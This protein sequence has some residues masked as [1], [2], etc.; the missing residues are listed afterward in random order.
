MNIDAED[1]RRHYA[2]LNDAALLELNPDDLVDM[3]R[4]CYEVELTR[5]GL[6]RERAADTEPDEAELVPAA[7][8]T[9]FQEAELGRMILE[10]ADIPCRLENDHDAYGRRVV[11]DEAFG[12]LWLLVPA[13]LVEDARDCLAS[14][15]PDPIS[16]E[17]LAKQAEAASEPET[18]TD[19]E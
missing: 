14:I 1:F 16:D 4:Q 15:V 8:Y 9:S 18:R 2:E 3:A 7:E 19:D 11:A 5:R 13:N 6:R 12:K 10:S 17:E